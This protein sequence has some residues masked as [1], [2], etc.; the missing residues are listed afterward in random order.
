MLLVRKAPGALSAQGA[1]L[2]SSR[3]VVNGQYMV[4]S[5]Y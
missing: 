5:N 2:I 1:L 3:H 4:H